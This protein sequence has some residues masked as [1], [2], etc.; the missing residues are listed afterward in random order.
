ML[1]GP[2]YSIPYCLISIDLYLHHHVQL[3]TIESIGSKSEDTHTNMTRTQGVRVAARSIF[4]IWIVK[5]IGAIVPG[6]VI[7]F[8]V[9]LTE[10]S[11]FT[12]C[13]PSPKLQFTGKKLDRR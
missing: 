13:D 7:L 5:A 2:L 3:D 4:M 11:D 9:Y 10:E 12:Q 6:G 1:C 8:L